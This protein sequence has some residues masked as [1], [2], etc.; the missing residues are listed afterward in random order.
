MRKYLRGVV[1]LVA[2]T[3]FGAGLAYAQAP[4]R[5]WGTG[6]MTP[7]EWKGEDFRAPANVPTEHFSGP[8]YMY[9]PNEYG[10]VAAPT[11]KHHRP[12]TPI[13]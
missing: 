3:T 9:A 11:A 7:F 2:V 4:A 1:T 13:R 6:N 12:N 8:L 10:G 5:G